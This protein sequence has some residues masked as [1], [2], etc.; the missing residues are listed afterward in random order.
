MF[1]FASP[2]NPARPITPQAPARAVRRAAEKGL[3]LAGFTPH[4]LRRTAA[5]KLAALGVEEAVCKRVLGHV[6][7]RSDVLASVY[8]RHSY[9]PEM[10][11]ALEKLEQHLLALVRRE[12]TLKIVHLQQTDAA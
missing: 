11:R 8:N 3:M 2:A 6:P 1:V 10:R 7:R 5:T 12:A 9:L 4:D